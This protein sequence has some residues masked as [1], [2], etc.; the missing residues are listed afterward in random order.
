MIRKVYDEVNFYQPKF[1]EIVR[2]FLAGDYG[3][4]NWPRDWNDKKL[5]LKNEPTM[6]WI[7][8]QRN[9]MEFLAIRN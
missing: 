6:N 4:W 5:P 9:T 7:L 3:Q 8:H 2:I 1:F